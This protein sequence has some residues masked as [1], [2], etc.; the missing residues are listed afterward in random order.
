MLCFE[1][2]VA[3]PGGPGPGLPPSCPFCRRPCDEAA[4]LPRELISL[5]GDSLVSKYF[6][7]PPA[8]ASAVDFLKVIYRHRE[9]LNALTAL[10]NLD[11]LRSFAIFF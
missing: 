1:D 7:D 9:D 4:P 8:L 11:A 3:G 5:A 6:S 10:K 2:R